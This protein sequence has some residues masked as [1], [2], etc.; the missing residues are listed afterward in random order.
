MRGVIMLSVES[1]CV[2][3]CLSICN[4]LTVESM[5]LEISFLVR[6][7]VHEVFGIYRFSSYVKVTGAKVSFL[8]AVCLRLE[9]S[10]VCQKI[11]LGFY[12]VFKQNIK[13]YIVFVFH[14]F[15]C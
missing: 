13:F 2:S 9:G 15:Y 14:K 11:S 6:R 10:L 1:F 12:L 7:Q 4:T 3:V 8:R 5:D